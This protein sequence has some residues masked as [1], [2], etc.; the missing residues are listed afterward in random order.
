MPDAQR[1][2]S[3]LRYRLG[4]APLQTIVWDTLDVSVGRLNTQDIVVPDSDVSREH[5]VFRRTD[6]QFTIEDQKSG[7]GTTVNGRPVRKVE[8]RQGDI[9]VIGPLR[10]QF[11]Q[12]PERPRPARDVRFASSLK[13][14]SAEPAPPDEHTGSRTMMFVAIDADPP[15]SQEVGKPEQQTGTR[16]LSASGQL[17]TVGE[18]FALGLALGGAHPPGPALDVRDLDAEL[19]DEL[20]DR[21]CDLDVGAAS[22]R[23][24]A[25]AS[26]SALQREFAPPARSL[27]QP[28][29][30]PLPT[31]DESPAPVTPQ[32]VAANSPATPSPR[33]APSPDRWQ[34]V[35]G[36][37]EVPASDSAPS[38]VTVKLAV[39][40]RGSPERIK[41][42]L[43]ALA[44][45]EIQ[46]AGLSVRMGPVA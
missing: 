24:A 46:I 28:T 16:A 4:N 10:L 22:N 23:E 27:P 15:P 6:G 41:T 14:A 8:L 18:D 44:E 12:T 25:A 17:E 29:S 31:L 13:A 26:A 1:L 5:A 21:E 3:L 36:Q 45:D 35:P 19:G 37:G 38:E 11:Q 32:P 20:P 40:V 9:I 30:S 7:L 43:A 2:Y 34:A 42:V 33:A 39:A